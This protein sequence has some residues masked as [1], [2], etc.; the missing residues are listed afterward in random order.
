MQ[1]LELDPPPPCGYIAVG[2]DY[3]IPPVGGKLEIRKDNKIQRV[4]SI[5]NGYACPVLILE[6]GEIILA[7]NVEWVGETPDIYGENNAC[8]NTE[9]ATIHGD[10]HHP[11]R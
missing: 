4:R 5:L 2:V 8:K 1:N 6:S 3:L 7:Y 9:T 10:V 11:E